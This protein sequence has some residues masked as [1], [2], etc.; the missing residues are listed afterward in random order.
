MDFNVGG[1]SIA[2]GDSSG[3]QRLAIDHDIADRY[4]AHRTQD[5]QLELLWE[6]YEKF[7]AALTIKCAWRDSAATCVRNSGR[8]LRAAIQPDFFFAFAAYQGAI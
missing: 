1:L 8:K 6:F 5:S 2:N 4:R 3:R 7:A